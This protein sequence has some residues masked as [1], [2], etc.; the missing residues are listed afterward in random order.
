MSAA[1]VLLEL[2]VTDRATMGVMGSSN[3]SMAGRY[4]H[5]TTPIKRSIADQVSEHLWEEA[6]FR[7]TAGRIRQHSLALREPH[8]R[9]APDCANA[10]P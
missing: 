2:G 1:T 5:I 9:A 10:N 4:Q 7:H 8:V 6:E 3:A